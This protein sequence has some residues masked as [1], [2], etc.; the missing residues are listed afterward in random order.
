MMDNIKE[1][2]SKFK[3]K[4]LRKALPKILESPTNFDINK[5]DTSGNAIGVWSKVPLDDRG[6]YC[7]YEN[8]NDRDLDYAFLMTLLS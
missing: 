7:Y 8:E 1:I 2:L 6:T 3:H 4:E 5:S